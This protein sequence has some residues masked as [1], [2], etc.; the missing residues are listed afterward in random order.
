MGELAQAI[1]HTC[2]RA[3]GTRG[4]HKRLCQEALEHA[5]AGVCVLPTRVTLCRDLLAA[6]ARPLAAPLPRVV[7]VVGFPLGAAL[8]AVKARETGLALRAGAEEIDMVWDLGA[9]K[10]GNLTTVLDDIRSVVEAADGAPVKVIVETAL[11]DGDEKRRA[12]ELV[13]QAGAAFIK[14]ST[15]FAGSGAT[16]A[17][18]RLFR[19]VAGTTLA[20]K[21]AGGIRDHATAVALL[22]AGADRLGTSAGPALLRS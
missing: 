7:T 10:D 13:A 2:L 8:E 16:V 12:A 21:A 17:D 5:F 22:D 15:G 14:T 19:Q 11:L 20:I 1:E 9:F 3:D 18:V 4:D 6:G